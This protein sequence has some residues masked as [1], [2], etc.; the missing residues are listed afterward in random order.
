MRAS[1]MRFITAQGVRSV[2]FLVAAGVAFAACTSGDDDATGG[3]GGKGGGAPASIVPPNWDRAVTKPADD[4]AQ[5]ARESCTFKAGAL[6]GETQGASHPDGKDIPVDHVLIVMMENRSFDHYFSKLP[7]YGQPDVEV[8]PAT[9]TN[10]DSM[11]NDVAPFHG[12]DYCFVDTNHEWDGTHVSYAD[13]KMDGFFLANDNHGGAPPH[14]KPDSLSGKRALAY[15]DQTDIPFYYWLAS[16]F[17]IADHYFCGLLGPT[18]PNRDYLYAASSRGA[19]TNTLVKFD[20]AKGYCSKE[21]PCANGAECVN[22]ACKGTCTK[23]EDCGFEPPIGTCDV[24]GGGTCK[25]IGRTIFDYLEVR[26]I[27]WKVYASGTPGFGLTLDAWLRYKDEHQKSIDDYYADAAAGKLP[28]VAF[29]DPAIGAEG[30]GQ[31]DEH[32]PSDMQF[33]QEFSA[34]I[35][36]ALMKSP[37]WSS[38]ALFLTYDEHGGL[39]DHVPPPKA[40]PPGDVPANVQPGDEPGE[41]DRYGVRV[42]MILVS[43]FA[44]KHFVAHGVYDH[45][46]ITRFVEARFNLPALTGRDANAAVPWEMFDFDTKPHLT[47]P[48]VTIPTI[49]QAKF[50]AC[51]AVFGD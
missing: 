12:T 10:R 24:A 19:I 3:K 39:F 25:P 40:C 36:D 45:T 32:P 51:K 31:N 48:A 7:E 29:I 21:L 27:D 14:P 50:D 13:G 9:Y 35:I 43:P 37:N 18:W 33:G 42:P 28:Q 5:S 44:K 6:A 46:S 2:G 26:K 49:D 8:F 16:E 17:S 20:D 4:A 11:M 47:P 41:F 22:Q 23:D 34:K 1:V 30:F 15:F 38:S